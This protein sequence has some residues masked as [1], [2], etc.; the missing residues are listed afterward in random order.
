MRRAGMRVRSA[1]VRA[2]G[3]DF[4]QNRFELSNGTHVA[5]DVQQV[6]RPIGSAFLIDALVVGVERNVSETNRLPA[7][8]VFGDDDDGLR[9]ALFLAF[10][11]LP[12]AFVFVFRLSSFVFYL[13]SALDQQFDR[14]DLLANDLQEPRTWRTVNHLVIAGE[15]QGDGINETHLAITTYRL[16]L[17]GADAENCHLR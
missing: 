10:C 3:L 7:E 1:F 2:L 16:G 9:H 15:G 6:V 17:N 5:P 8:D 13:A 11:L 12:F 14:L 4:V